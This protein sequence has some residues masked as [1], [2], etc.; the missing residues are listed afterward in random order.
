V[1]RQTRQVH[2]GKDREGEDKEEREQDPVRE[3]SCGWVGT[4]YVGSSRDHLWGY[5]NV[6][7]IVCPNEII[8]I[9]KRW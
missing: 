7:N 6:S 9:N 1:L 4:L 2:Q 3:S 5:Q 8:G